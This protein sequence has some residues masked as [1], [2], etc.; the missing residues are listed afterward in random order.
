MPAQMVISNLQA[1]LVVSPRELGK[2]RVLAFQ[3][4]KEIHEGE[5]HFRI[6]V[7]YRHAKLSCP[8]YAG[9]PCVIGPAAII[10]FNG[11]PGRKLILSCSGCGAVFGILLVIRRRLGRGF[12]HLL[13]IGDIST[14]D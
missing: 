4:A 14:P 1:L 8:G 10:S 7:I 9:S 5:I 2:H 3:A 12:S 6:L 11:Y 13:R